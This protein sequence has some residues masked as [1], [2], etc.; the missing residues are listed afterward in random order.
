MAI[1]A[2]GK[3]GFATLQQDGL[4]LQ[5]YVRLDAVGEQ[6]FALYKLLDLGVEPDINLQPQPI[7]LQGRKARLALRA[8]E[9][10]RPPTAT[11]GGCASSSSAVGAS[12]CAPP[13]RRW[14][15]ASRLAPAGKLGW[16][17][18]PDPAFQISFS[19]SW[20]RVKRFCSNS[21]STRCFLFVALSL[22]QWLV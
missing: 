22:V 4:R 6:G 2:Q 20:R 5:I 7:L 9:N 13:P 16:D 8:G 3:A 15:P 18:P 11:T 21:E 14:S 12:H 17:A 19:F 1:R 10:D